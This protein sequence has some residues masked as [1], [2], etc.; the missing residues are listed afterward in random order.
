[1][2]YK[3][4]SLLRERIKNNMH[5]IWKNNLMGNNPSENGYPV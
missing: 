2:H 1:M 3:F 5:R 4:Y